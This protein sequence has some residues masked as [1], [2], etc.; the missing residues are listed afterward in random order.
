[1]TGLF[2]TAFESLIWVVPVSLTH[3]WVTACVPTFPN[4]DSICNFITIWGLKLW[5]LI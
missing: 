1:M 2:E 3:I 4:I 5:K